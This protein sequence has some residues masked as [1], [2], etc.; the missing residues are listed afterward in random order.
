MTVSSTTFTIAFTDQAMAALKSNLEPGYGV[1]IAFAGGCGALAYRIAPSRKAYP[2]D[3]V[4]SVENFSV[5]VDRRGARELDGA[6]ID[7][8]PEHGFIIDDAIFGQ[9][10]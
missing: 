4:F 1:R 10:C 2:G 8:S 5:F 6:E 7:Y 3:I 9:S